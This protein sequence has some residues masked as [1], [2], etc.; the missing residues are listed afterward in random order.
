MVT[1]DSFGNPI[2]PSVSYARGRVLADLAGEARRMLNGRRI[3]RERI[4]S[5]AR[6][7]KGA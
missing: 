2:D 6:G 1:T 7:E 3:V 5:V 4:G